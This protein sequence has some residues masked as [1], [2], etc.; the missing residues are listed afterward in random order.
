[1]LTDEQ[2]TRSLQSAG[3][4]GVV[5]M[6]FESGPY[7]IDRPTIKASRFAEQI[8]SA[9]TA[10]LLARIAELEQ[11]LD[12]MAKNTEAQ[13]HA[14]LQREIELTEKVEKLTRELEEARKDAE[15]LD[16]IQTNG[17]TVE[18]IPGAPDF[19]PVHFR[20]GGRYS[21]ANEN[22]RDAIRAAIKE[23]TK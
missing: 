3:C 10:P 23:Q 2:I 20:V 9:A 12:V 5:R 15:L 7:C 8:E 21:T 13:A 6:S 11:Q 16:Y 1:M 4:A 19:Y 17:A 14:S 22:I 18:I